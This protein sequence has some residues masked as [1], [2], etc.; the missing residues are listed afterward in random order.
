MEKTA[1]GPGREACFGSLLQV[2]FVINLLFAAYTGDVTAL[3]RWLHSRSHPPT[4]AFSHLPS[5]SLTSYLIS[6][7]SVSSPE[8]GCGGA[9]GDAWFRVL[10]G[11]L[12]QFA[13]LQ[14]KQGW[15]SEPLV[16]EVT[17]N[18]RCD[19]ALRLLSR[20]EWLWCNIL[21]SYS[22]CAGSRCP[23]WTWSNGTMTPEQPSMSQ[24][25]KVTHIV[26]RRFQGL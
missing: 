21:H 7:S 11:S 9:D 3:R 16:S 18:G 24:L 12:V 5:V 8:G 13:N 19:A 22:A 25:L 1:G 15:R 17:V 20:T 26:T 23:R 2:K 10:V 6:G 4:G 14:N